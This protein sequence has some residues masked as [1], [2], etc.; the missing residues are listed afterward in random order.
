LEKLWSCAQGAADLYH[1][2]FCD[3]A[4]HKTMWRAKPRELADEWPAGLDTPDGLAERVSYRGSNEHKAY[5]SFA[6]PPAKRT[7]ATPCDPSVQEEADRVAA[8]RALRG[9]IRRGC[10]SFDVR[11]NFPRY[12]WGW[13]RGRLYKAM[14]INQESG[15]Y[16]AWP[17]E[18]IETPDDPHGRLAEELW[19]E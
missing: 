7:D 15:W 2:S 13:F 9:A 18:A 8:E 5:P 4:K 3:M 10:V 16:K 12:V 6:G 1:T 14:L 11:G 17:I 19:N